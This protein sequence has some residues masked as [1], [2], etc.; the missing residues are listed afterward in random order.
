MKNERKNQ[1]NR[2]GFLKLAGGASALV[3]AQA[4]LPHVDGGWGSCAEEQAD[5][6]PAL[7]PA[8]HRVVEVLAPAAVDVSTLEIDAALVASM[9]AAGLLALTDEADLSA[10]WA[11]IMPE[12]LPGERIALKANALN[13]DVPTRPELLIAIL[14]SLKAD[15]SVAAEDLFVWDRTERE[16]ERAG[17]VAETIGAACLG[18][19]HSATDTSG[20]GYVDGSVCLSGQ[21]IQLSALLDQ[22]DHLINVPVMKNHFAAGFTGCMK[23]HYGSFQNPWDYHDGSD[24]HIARLNAIPEVAGTTRLMVMDALIG[25]CRRDTDAAADCVPSRILLSFDPV[26]ID[27]RGLEIRDEM[28]ALADME[29][30]PAAGYLQIGEEMG[31][32]STQYDLVTIEL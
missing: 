5:L 28:R 25:V 7:V 9:F 13:Q 24:Q 17:I 12:R 11:A 23:N 15:L 29:P 4:C 26:A 30:G 20:V 32:G 16:L 27:Q 8:S 22:V 10:A 3:T 14:D 1:L 31:L 19:I 18:T 6:D 21:K 2:R